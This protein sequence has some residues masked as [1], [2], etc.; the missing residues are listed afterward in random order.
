MPLNTLQLL[1][2]ASGLTATDIAT[3]I[4]RAGV[5][6]VKAWLSGDKLPG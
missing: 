5:A 4:P 6:T 1:A 2:K 3:A